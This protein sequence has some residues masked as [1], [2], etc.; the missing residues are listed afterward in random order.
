MYVERVPDEYTELARF[1]DWWGPDNPNVGQLPNIDEVRIDVII[2]Q[3]ARIL[4]MRSGDADTERYE[5]FGA[6]VDEV[7]GYDELQL[8]SSFKM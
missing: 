8:F 7:L 3:D 4:A 5:I 2:G 6:Y 1:D